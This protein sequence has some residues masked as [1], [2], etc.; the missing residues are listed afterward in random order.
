MNLD[1]RV[2]LVSTE[3][4]QLLQ[5]THRTV[6]YQIAYGRLR[7]LRWEGARSVRI[8]AQGLVPDGV[9]PPRHGVLGLAD[10]SE[11]LRLQ[12]RQTYS[13]VERGVVPMT[14]RGWAW[15]I[16]AATLADW[17]AAASEGEHDREW[18]RRHGVGSC[19]GKFF[20]VNLDSRLDQA[21]L[22]DK[23]REGGT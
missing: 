17:I 18:L 23:R 19:A 20:E 12:V 10:V 3:V 2:L 14:K 16:S 22:V 9:G 7:V 11:I 13:L 5:V 1:G 4:Q 15:G 8:H 6:S 21:V